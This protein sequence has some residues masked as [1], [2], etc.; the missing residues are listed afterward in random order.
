MPTNGA[1]SGAGYVVFAEPAAAAPIPALSQ[2][3]ADAAALLLG[4]LGWLK[5]RRRDSQRS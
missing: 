3:G 5:I 1:D 2:W 4:G